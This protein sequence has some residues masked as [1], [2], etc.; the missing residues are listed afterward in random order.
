MSLLAANGDRRIRRRSDIAI[1]TLG[2]KRRRNEGAV[3]RSPAGNPQAKTANQSTSRRFVGSLE[4][5]TTTPLPLSLTT[6]T[7]ARGPLSW[8]RLI[9]FGRPQVTG[10]RSMSVR[11]AVEFDVACAEA[12]QPGDDCDRPVRCHEGFQCVSEVEQIIGQLL[13]HLQ[14]GV[15]LCGSL[16]LIPLWS[17]IA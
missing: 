10:V 14:R 9:R 16:R 3:S 13:Q 2:L 4:W 6:S 5:L 1:D 17:V 11:S 15:Y 7:R 8:F 12:L